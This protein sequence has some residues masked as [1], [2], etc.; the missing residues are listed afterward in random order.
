MKHQPKTAASTPS[1]GGLF[2]GLLVALALSAAGGWQ[3][4]KLF[5][6]LPRTHVEL[7]DEHKPDLLRTAQTKPLR[8]GS[9]EVL[10]AQD[11]RLLS[12]SLAKATH[13]DGE[14]SRLRGVISAR[15]AAIRTPQLGR[16][17]QAALMMLVLE[18]TDTP[19][20]TWWTS[21]E[22]ILRGLDEASFAHHQRELEDAWTRSHENIG[23]G[24]ATSRRMA[25]ALCGSPHTAFLQVFVPRIQKVIDER[26]AV[27]DAKTATML[28]RIAFRLLKTWVLEPGPPGVRLLAAELLREQLHDRKD[29]S[30]NAIASNLETWRESYRESVRRLPADV[31]AYAGG[32]V[33]TPMQ[34][35]RLAERLALSTW[36]LGAALA[37]SIPALALV[38]VCIWTGRG[39][40]LG[41]GTWA[42]STFAALTVM[43]CG[44]L[45]IHLRPESIWHDLR[46]DGDGIRYWW[47]HPFIA[48]AVALAALF[49]GG[50]V[51]RRRAEGGTRLTSWAATALLSWCIL[52]T[53][54]IGTGLTAEHARV[55]YEQADAPR[56]VDPIKTLGGAQADKLLDGVRAWQP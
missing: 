42:T 35:D 34:H 50:V 55:R 40:R 27:G 14:L 28:Q 45:W 3:I 4:F 54:L 6:R 24:P 39:E 36:T 44:L 12:F 29:A 30:E 25:Q 33:L 43:L 48:A 32:P 53:S 49:A 23:L 21:L 13:D 31:F 18:R 51:A 15:V 19:I 10:A 1:R 20:A 11:L 7:L 56:A 38:V 47:R 5:V 52:A 17:Q 41:L 2:I 37:A 46:S 22:P 26:E 8:S 16:L 9:P